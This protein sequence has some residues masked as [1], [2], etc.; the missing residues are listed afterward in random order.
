NSRLTSSLVD[1]LRDAG[2]TWRFAAIAG[3]YVDHISSADL[4]PEP[5][6]LGTLADNLTSD[7]VLLRESSIVNLSHLL[8]N[9]KRLSKLKFP[10]IV[11]ASA[12]SVVDLG[13]TGSRVLSELPYTEL[14]ERALAGGN[15]SDAALAPYLDNPSTGWFVWP[16][17]AKIH[18]VSKPGGEMAFSKIDPESQAA[19]DAVRNIL[20]S[21]GK[22]DRIAKLFSQ[23]SARPSG[24]GNFGI[25]HA[26]FYNQ[27]FSLYDF[28]ML[29]KAWPAI[30][31]LALDIERT[32]AQRAASEMVAGVLRGSKHWSRESLEKMWGLVIP[33]L[34]TV[35]SKLRPDTIRFWQTCLRFAFA[36]RDPR[37]FLP[38]VRLIIYGSPF[39]PQSEAPFTEAAKLE[40]LLLLLNSWDWRVVSA[41]AASK[42]RLFEA[43]AHPYKQVRDSAGILMYTMSSSEYSVSY[44]SV[45]LAMDDLARY[46]AT[47]RDFS[48]WAGSQQ[49]QSMIEK[50]TSQVTLWKA[51]H[52]PSNEGT[53]NYSRGSKT[54]L[55]FFIAGFSYSSK[56][57]SAEHI[58]PILPM[59]SVL[60]EQSDDEEV[61]RLAKALMQYLAQVLYTTQMSETVTS[62]MLALLEEEANSWHVIT[63]TLPLLCTLTFSNRFTLS[64]DVRM[65]IVD[66]TALF[67]EHDQI[68][69]RQTASKSLTSLVKCASSN[70]IADI[71]SK[72][73]VKIS[74]PLPRVRYGRP[75]KDPVAYGRLALT[76]HA[77]VLGLSC[78]VL[79][80]PYTI[81]DW[82]PEVLILLAGCIDDPNPIQSTVQRTFAEF[83]RTHM[84]TWHEDRKKFTISQL[85]LLTDMLV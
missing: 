3:Y 4:P 32:G 43:L 65:K 6:L 36:R 52:I 49:T 81:P 33:L 44:T 27:A 18:T 42:P 39:D 79:A 16:L 74:T 10:D 69:V 53:S 62:K 7:L 55:T 58:P 22:W 67:L 41:I 63:K 14:C 68:E 30:E 57:L 46:G 28:P 35:F 78:L 11:A 15:D 54:L 72:F 34:S 51:D 31:Q 2:T 59:F 24:E 61:A 13:G 25:S 38:L 20:L 26:S 45:E 50:M 80:F 83:R 19:Y 1:I 84:D 21:D 85:E 9:I 23:E 12:R 73:S 8:S 75:P 29:E 66:T 77:G 76:R 60:Q 64:H 48:H 82:L 40:L 17:E 37:R 47:G 70:V 71:N 5:R 56:R